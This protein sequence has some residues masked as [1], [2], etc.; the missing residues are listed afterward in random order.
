MPYGNDTEFFYALVS[1][2]LAASVSSQLVAG[3]NPQRKALSI[4][5]DSP[6]PAFLNINAPAS[7]AAWLVR[8]PS[9]Q[10][11]ELPKP[12]PTGSV[13]IACGSAS[14][15]IRWMDIS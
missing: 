3:V 7:S 2:T 12:C 4:C 6:D 15:S 11:Y 8:I 1:G 14:G 9:Y 13:Y 5:V 10:V